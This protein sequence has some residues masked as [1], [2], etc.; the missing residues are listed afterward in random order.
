M[1]DLP[2]YPGTPRWVKI[3]GIVVIVLVLLIAIIMFTGVG[4]PHGPGRHIP[5]GGAGGHTAL[6]RQEDYTWAGGPG[7]HTPPIEHG[8]R[9]L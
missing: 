4:S 6:Q 7:G 8:V 9:Q 2:A 1:A 5:A 3:V